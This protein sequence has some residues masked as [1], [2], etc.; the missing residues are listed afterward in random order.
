MGAAV[1][2]ADA[3][4]WYSFCSTYFTSQVRDSMNDHARQ[5][6]DNY[7]AYYFVQRRTLWGVAIL[8]IFKMARNVTGEQGVEAKVAKLR[9][10][11]TRR[12]FGRSRLG[13]QLTKTL[14]LATCFALFCE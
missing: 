7:D 10:L 5:S 2:S 14:Y 11:L 3:V 13:R 4:L 8:D 6:A 9:W 12:V 1:G